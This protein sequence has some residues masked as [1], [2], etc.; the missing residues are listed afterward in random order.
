VDCQIHSAEERLR[1]IKALLPH[2]S[3]VKELGCYRE[4][5]C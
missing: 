4:A 1:A 5:D 3:M 2:C